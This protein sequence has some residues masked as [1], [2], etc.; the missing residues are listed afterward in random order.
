MVGQLANALFTSPRQVEGTSDS[1]ALPTDLTPAIATPPIPL[2]EPASP[3]AAPLRLDGLG[4]PDLTVPVLDCP[5][6][7]ETR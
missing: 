3:F 7:F 6:L 2:H 1:P 4:A 5:V